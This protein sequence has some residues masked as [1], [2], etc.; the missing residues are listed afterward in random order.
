M[1]YCELKKK[2]F[3]LDN[4]GDGIV[5]VAGMNSNKDNLTVDSQHNNCDQ[6]LHDIYHNKQN[7]ESE[8]TIDGESQ[9]VDIDD[10]ERTKIMIGQYKG[11]HMRKVVMS[12]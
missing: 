11:S 9:E 10:I 2:Y 8:N 7:N 5:T 4:L 6:E 1:V 12:T 3:E